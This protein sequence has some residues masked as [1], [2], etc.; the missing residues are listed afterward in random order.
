MALATRCPHCN[1][2]FRVASDQLKLRGGIVRCG[3]CHQVFD[4]N[5]TLLDLDAPLTVAPE[6]QAP[7]QAAPD[8]PSSIPVG[9]PAALPADG[10]GAPAPEAAEAAQEPAIPEWLARAMDA[11][12]KVEAVPS[13]EFEPIVFKRDAEPAPEASAAPAAP[14]APPAPLQYSKVPTPEPGAD[15]PAPPRFLLKPELRG[16][17]AAPA[18]PKVDKS[19]LAAL[20]EP[21]LLTDVHTMAPRRDAGVP[22]EE[23]QHAALDMDLSEEAVPAGASLPEPAAVPEPA[24]APE[25]V[26]S[27][28]P[29]IISEPEAVPEDVSA[30][31]AMPLAQDTPALPAAAAAPA[32]LEGPKSEMVFTPFELPEPEEAEEPEPEPAGPVKLAPGYVLDYDLSEPDASAKPEPDLDPVTE[33]GPE[34]EE[35]AKAQLLRLDAGPAPISKLELSVSDE[36][37]FS[38]VDYPDDD[39]PIIKAAPANVPS[40]EPEREPGPEPD[41]APAAA[42][43][44]GPLP[45]LREAAAVDVHEAEPLPAYAPHAAAPAEAIEDEPEFVRLAREKEL[46]ARRL[47][48]SMTIGS[49]VLLLALIGQGAYVFRTMLAAHYPALKPALVAGCKLV[50]CKITLP[51]QI[52]LVKIEVGELQTLGDGTLLL[53]TLVRNESELTQ[54]WP[55]IH[56]K[57]KDDDKNP[58]VRRVFTPAQYLPAGVSAANGFP[59]MSEQPVKIRF[60]LKQVK[61][62][63]YD[64]EVFYP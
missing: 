8:I 15:L 39:E 31:E 3:T 45:L 9:V 5:A 22:A 27:A 16:D 14:V 19:A 48:T 37:E 4:G 11:E 35:D 52:D 60:A 20:V 51:A 63:G 44:D 24:P 6:M 64:I 53:T 29:E 32:D 30:A 47:R 12:V 33:M 7:P 50:G 36:V 25:P 57:L 41:L 42:P 28:A 49:V 62:S 2:T 43:D 38:S 18:A 17:T 23:A 40:S 1:T 21:E 59:P 56:L 46:A 58:L 26:V 13:I 55:Y 61:A 34:L 10:A 54:A